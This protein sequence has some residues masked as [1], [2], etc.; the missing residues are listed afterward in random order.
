MILRLGQ[1][2]RPMSWISHNESAILEDVSSCGKEIRA[3]DSRVN[4]HRE[5]GHFAYSRFSHW[6]GW[7]EIYVLIYRCYSEAHPG[8]TFLLAMPNLRL[9]D[10]A[11]APITVIAAI[12]LYC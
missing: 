3:K 9:H 6:T 1:S 11:H 5:V 10:A 4:L 12:C 2:I 7:S 8:L